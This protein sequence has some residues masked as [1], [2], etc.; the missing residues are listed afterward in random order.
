MYGTNIR[1]LHPG[2][3]H[4]EAILRLKLLDWTPPAQGHN[5]AGHSDRG[6]VAP[7][8]WPSGIYCSKSRPCLLRAAAANAIPFCRGDARV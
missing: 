8:E 4:E 5:I 1:V 7:V 3:F 6:G 2:Q